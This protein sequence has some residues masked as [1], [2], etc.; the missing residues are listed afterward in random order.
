VIAKA[1]CG[2]P[3][4]TIDHAVSMARFAKRC[5]LKMWSLV[6]RLEVSPVP[7]LV[8]L[9]SPRLEVLPLVSTQTAL[10]PDTGDLTLRI[11]LHSGPVTAVSTSATAVLILVPFE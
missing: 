11:G 10:G 4:P 1:V 3:E 7:Y 9:G 5:L 8:N 6:K 2:L